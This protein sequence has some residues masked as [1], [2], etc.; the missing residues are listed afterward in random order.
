MTD[1]RKAEIVWL[2]DIMG[3]DFKYI[4]HQDGTPFPSFPQSYHLTLCT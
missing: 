2:D 3:E 1:M 4:E